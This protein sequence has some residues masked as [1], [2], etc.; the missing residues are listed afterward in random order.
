MASGGGDVNIVLAVKE[1][2]CKQTGQ[3]RH[4]REETRWGCWR[5]IDAGVGVGGGVGGVTCAVVVTE[6][7]CR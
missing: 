4:C 3:R 6:A 1:I 2:G 7:G 5:C